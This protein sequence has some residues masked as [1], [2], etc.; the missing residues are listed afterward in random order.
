M[1]HAL[2]PSH[3]AYVNQPFDSLFEFYESAVIGDA[4]HPSG[5]VRANGIAMRSI[6]PWVRRELF[7]SERNALLIFVELQHLYLN[8]IADVNQIAGMSEPPP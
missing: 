1:L 6:Q 7:E 2:G 8:L 5:N 3:L 4:D